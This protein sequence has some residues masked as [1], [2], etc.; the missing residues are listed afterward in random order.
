MQ[1]S[2]RGPEPR[3]NPQDKNGQGYRKMGSTAIRPKDQ[4]PRGTGPFKSEDNRTAD[5]T[6]R[7]EQELP[8]GMQ[9][10][11]AGMNSPHYHKS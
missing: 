10:P 11:E 9:S 2:G 4:P 7:Q 6:E 8:G 5:A 1:Q 3:R